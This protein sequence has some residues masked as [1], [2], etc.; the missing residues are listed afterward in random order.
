MMMGWEIDHNLVAPLAN[1]RAPRLTKLAIIGDDAVVP[2]YRVENVHSPSAREYNHPIQ[3][4]EVAGLEAK[5]RDDGNPTL[6]DSRM[7]F[8]GHPGYL[9]SDVPYGVFA[10]MATFD[11]LLP[12][13]Y[14]VPD[15]DVGR[16]FY[17]SP[18]ELVAG[19]DAYERPIDLRV[20]QTIGAAFYGADE[21]KWYLSADRRRFLPPLYR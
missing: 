13:D 15:M 6:M 16:I 12:V 8:S 14:P 2:F 4:A 19:I 9:M 5:L 7:V 20:A 18:L 3:T 11:G 1:A 21:P 17:D 10:A